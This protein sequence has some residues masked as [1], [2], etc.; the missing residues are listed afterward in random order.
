MSNKELIIVK[1]NVFTKIVKFF[2][3]LFK[4]N[5][6]AIEVDIVNNENIEKIKEEKIQKY[7]ED[8]KHFLQLYD[9]VKKGEVDLLSLEQEQ[10]KRICVLLEEEIK[11]EDSI[12]EK[13]K[14]KLKKYA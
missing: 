3:R 12:I 6:N 11:I 4:K 8:K 1:E 14:E 2:K 5:R 7:E 9:Q 10:L 13:T